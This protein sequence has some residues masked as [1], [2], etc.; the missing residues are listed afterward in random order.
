MLLPAMMSGNC[1]EKYI[2]ATI[3]RHIKNESV[4]V[5]ICI[6]YKWKNSEN[7][8]I[9]ILRYFIKIVMTTFG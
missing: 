1:A 2:K 8:I 6:T 7:N 5:C 3:Y 4:N 9:Y